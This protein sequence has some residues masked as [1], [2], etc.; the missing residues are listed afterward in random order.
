[1]KNS[2]VNV[3]DNIPVGTEEPVLVSRFLNDHDFAAG[4]RRLIVLDVRQFARWFADANREP[5][6]VSRVTVRDVVDFREHLRREKEH[7]V[8][9]VNRSLVLLRRFF[10]WLAEQGTI[11]LNPVKQ[12]KELRRVQL[13]PKGLDRSHVRRLLREAELRKDIRAAAIFSLFLFTGGRVGDLVHL[14]LQDVLITERSGSVVFRFGKGGKERSVP[15]PL[16]ARRVLQAY[17]DTRPPVE[18]RRVFIGERGP[19]TDRGMRALLNKYSAVIGVKLFPHLLRHTMAHEFLADNNN[20]LVALAQILG[21][22]S[23]STT[24]RYV[25]RTQQELG[26]ATDRLD[27]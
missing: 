3:F 16:P 26:E 6:T 20:D 12:V 18:S 13:A 4:T 2:S 22:E 15:L 10:G 25:Q 8:A 19:L 14:E 24:A 21:H 1:M 27:Y 7:A 17:L 23:L 9:T 5:F 11:P